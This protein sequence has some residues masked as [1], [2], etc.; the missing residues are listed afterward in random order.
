MMHY[1]IETYPLPISLGMTTSGGGS[2]ISGCGLA[3]PRLLIGSADSGFEGGPADL[4]RFGFTMRRIIMPMTRRN[5]RKRIL[6]L[7]YLR[8]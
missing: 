4:E 6:R 5:S 2:A 1:P 8:W 7:V 3:T